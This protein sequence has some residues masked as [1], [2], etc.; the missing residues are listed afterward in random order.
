MP[1]QI[2]YHK[3]T[4]TAKGREYNLFDTEFELYHNVARKT[5]VST[6]QQRN[7]FFFFFFYDEKKVEPKLTYCSRK[8]DLPRSYIVTPQK[9]KCLENTKP[10][11]KLVKQPTEEIEKFVGDFVN[12]ALAL[13]E[14]EIKSCILILTPLNMKYGHK[15]DEHIKTLLNNL[16]VKPTDIHNHFNAGCG[17][18]VFNG[19]VTGEFKK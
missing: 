9:D 1:Y 13:S 14:D 4:N 8:K 7:G 15:F 19:P 12:T 16:R 17:C 18:L 3:E 11:G 6:T 5:D 10:S 2:Y